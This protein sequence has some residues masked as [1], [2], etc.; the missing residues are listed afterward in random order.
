MDIFVVP[1]ISFRPR[2]RLCLWRKFHP[3]ASCHG[4][5]RPANRAAIAMAEWPYGTADC[6]NPTEC[7]DHVVPLA[8]YDDK[9]VDL[10]KREFDGYDRHDLAG[11]RVCV[12]QW[13]FIPFCGR[14]DIKSSGGTFAAC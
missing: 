7:L 6:L 5:S 12:L 3:A 10:A 9:R 4:H 1:T 14:L 11:F 8:E 2:S 13:V